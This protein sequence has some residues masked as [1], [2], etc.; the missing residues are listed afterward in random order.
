MRAAVLL[1]C[2]VLC[3]TV[4][5][6]AGEPAEALWEAARVGDLTAVKKLHAEGFDLNARTKYGATALSFACD[7]G[8]LDVARYL[9]EHGADVNAKDD[10]YQVTPLGWALYNDHVEIVKL[11]V[12]NGASEVDQVLMTGVRKNVPELVAIA[13]ESDEIDPEVVLQALAQARANEQA[14]EI[15]KLLE[16]SEVKPVPRPEVTVAPEVLQSYTGTY[17]NS[18]IDMTI[19]VRVEEGRLVAQATG[20]PPLVMRA[21]SESRF[22]AVEVPQVKLSFS[23]RGGT[24]ERAVVE[25]GSQQ[26]VFPRFTAQAEATTTPVEEAAPPEEAPE[27][28]IEIVRKPAQNWPS[29]RGPGASGIADG[30]GAPLEWDVESGRNVRWKTPL[31]GMGNSSPIV[32]GDRVFVTTAISMGGDDT[33]RSGLYG[34]V[35]SV[36]DESEHIFNVYALDKK[37]GEILWERTVAKAVP[38]AKRHLK[39]TQANSTPVTDGKRVVALFGTIG[40]LV[41]YDLDGNLQWKTDVGTLDAGWFYDPSYQWGHASS[42]I[43]YEDLVIVQADVYKNSFIA[44]YRLADGKQVW[45]TARDEVPSWGSPTV[46]RGKE[47]HE[48]ITNGST[49]RGYDPATGKALWRLGPNSEVTVATPIVAHDLFFVTA[50]YPPARPVYAIRPGASGDI[51]LPENTD[52]SAAVAWSKSRGGTYIPTPLVYGDYLYTCHNDGR[53][54]CYDAKTGEQIYRARV[55]GRGGT[56]TASPVAADGRLYFTDE[57]GEVY[58]VRAGK[59]YEDLALNSMG[60]ICMSTPAISDGV[61]VVRTLKHVYGIGE[62]PQAR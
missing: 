45:R 58:V 12:A 1:V 10:F 61:M 55:G 60:E 14:E 18:E 52:S 19:E 30:Q 13:L 16:S 42:P 49:I 47:R 39:S 43:I 37:T 7:K 41:A 3:S 35:D 29:F 17:K 22:E 62:E 59:T 33:F 24:I 4:S 8:H 11:L 51:S 21:L 20:Q 31:P 40:L 32:W 5:G 15:V 36:D 54:T 28:E 23:G 9:I 48:L 46:Y 38:G 34:D 57:S 53:M 6:S 56:F 27:A 25:Q 44:A 26:T 2:L 50:G